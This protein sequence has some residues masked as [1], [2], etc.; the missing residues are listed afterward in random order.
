MPKKPKLILEK[1]STLAYEGLG[2]LNIKILELIKEIFS[3]MK[4]IPTQFDNILIRNNFWKKGFEYFFE[5]QWNNIYHNQFVEFFNLYL[6][7]EEKHKVLSEYLFNNLKIQ[8]LLINY[9]NQ[10]KNKEK[11]TE[12][13]IQNQKL[14]FFYKS[15]KS[16]RSGVYPH[17]IDLIYKIQ[18]IRGLTIFTE[19]EKIQL[20]I[21]NFGEFE[22]SKDEK[23]NKFII[24]IPISETINEILKDSKEWNETAENIVIPLVKKYEG[25]LCKKIELKEENE[26]DD[27]IM[28]DIEPIQ[29][30][31]RGSSTLLLQQLLSVIKREKPTKRFSMPLSRNEKNTLKPKIDKSSIRDKLINKVGIH[32]QKIFLDDEDEKN[33]ENNENKNDEKKEENNTEE[34]KN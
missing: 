20:K 16:T 29:R 33:K 34:N 19:E 14:H 24:K 31:S 32:N 15:R 10:D 22:F 5:Y 4:E 6:F 25:K 30:K 13:I 12:K 9:L 2:M 27:D 26:D 3:F 18:S 21:K 28:G 8:Q 17:V 7:N 1:G 23:S 11:K